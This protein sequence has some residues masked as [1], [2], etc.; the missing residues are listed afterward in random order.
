MRMVGESQA[1]GIEM[2]MHEAEGARGEEIRGCV[3]ISDIIGAKG[4]RCV[5]EPVE[6]NMWD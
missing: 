4:E 5:C 1:V 3:D 6:R 2:V